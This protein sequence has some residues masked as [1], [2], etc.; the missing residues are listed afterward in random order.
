MQEKEEGSLIFEVSSVITIIKPVS[1][2][3]TL[4]EIDPD[5]VESTAT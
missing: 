2:S 5:T 4:G 3:F 1:H